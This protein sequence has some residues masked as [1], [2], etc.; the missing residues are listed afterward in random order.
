MSEGIDLKD[1]GTY[2]LLVEFMYDSYSDFP[3]SVT[4]DIDKLGTRPEI[5]EV[6]TAKLNKTKATLKPGE[7]FNLKVTLKPKK[8]TDKSIT[9]KS[10]NKK[11][12][13]V[14]KNG[15]VTAKKKGTCTITAV[16]SNGKKAKC[17]ITVKK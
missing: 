17:K 2:T 13:T 4:F 3:V 5:I 11:V 15:K 14:D 10:S 12:A 7:S 6:K 8:V 1:N 16:T 9:W